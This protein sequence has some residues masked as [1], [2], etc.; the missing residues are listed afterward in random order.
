MRRLWRTL[1]RVLGDHGGDDVS[2]HTPDDF[3][4]FFKD[5]VES[6]RLSTSTT[7]SY[8][9]PHRMVPTLDEWTAVSV[10]EVDKLLG[11]ALCK[12]CQLDPAPTWLVKE[13][14]VAWFSTV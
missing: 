2:V 4:T 3:A 9:V 13:L 6:V 14:Q 8:D 7:P 11:S 12:T 1:K 5:K 10:D